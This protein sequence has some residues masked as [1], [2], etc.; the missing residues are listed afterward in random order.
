MIDTSIQFHSLQDPNSGKLKCHKKSHLATWIFHEGSFS[1]FVIRR[2][3]TF[4]ISNFQNSYSIGHDNGWNNTQVSLDLDNVVSLFRF[5]IKVSIISSTGL[6][7]ILMI[8]LQ[9]ST[10]LYLYFI[11][12]FYLNAWVK[13]AL[14]PSFIL[15][16][17]TASIHLDTG[18]V[19]YYS[20]RNKKCCRLVTSAFNIFGS[21]YLKKVHVYAFL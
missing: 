21:K 11:Y 18:L 5:N 20:R 10:E 12:L 15:G 13:G 7:C 16:C 19:H 3:E 4:I 1:G 9:L 6:Y 2:P 17:T 8:I 14:H